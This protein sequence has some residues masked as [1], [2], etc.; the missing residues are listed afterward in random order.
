[1][2]Y[3][4]AG[5]ISVLNVEDDNHKLYFEHIMVMVHINV[6][7]RYFFWSI[8]GQMLE[9]VVIRIFPQ[10]IFS[11]WNFHMN[12]MLETAIL[13]STGIKSFNTYICNI[14]GYVV[15]TVNTLWKTQVI[16]V[17]NLR[18]ESYQTRQ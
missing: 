4:S 2:P 16:L 10:V 9:N 5:T 1:M 12:L 14:V 8:P 6:W 18:T 11:N 13:K 3:V 7:L 17:A 15:H